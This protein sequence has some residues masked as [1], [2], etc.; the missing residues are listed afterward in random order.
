VN[1]VVWHTISRI[2]ANLITTG[3]TGYFFF[4]FFFFFVH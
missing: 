1:G 3:C 4:F 2:A